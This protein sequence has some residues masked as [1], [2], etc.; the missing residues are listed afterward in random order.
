MGLDMYAYAVRKEEYSTPHE[1]GTLPEGLE[2]W[3]ISYW[4]KFNALHGWMKK[5]YEKKGGEDEF[6]CVALHLTKDDLDALELD[7]TQGRL[8]TTSGFF[9]GEQSIE[10]EDIEDLK[11][12]LVK[13]RALELT[14]HVFYDSWW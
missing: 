13:A 9:F 12:F 5:L 1:F 11:L 4:R 7:M 3:K 6:N 14:H 8:K 10:P 2:V